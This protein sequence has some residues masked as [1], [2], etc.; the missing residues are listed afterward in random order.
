VKAI[1]RD[2]TVRLMLARTTELVEEARRLHHTSPTATAA[3]GRALTAAAMM[4]TDLKSDE[5]LTI[6]IAGGG[7]LGA[8][9]VAARSDG[10]VRGYVHEPCVDLP[11]QEP[12]KLDVGAAVGRDGFL[13]VVRDMGLRT[14]FSGSVPL[15]SGE[16]AEDFAYYFTVSEQI[17]S[18]VSLGVRVERDHRVSI[19]GGLIIQ[20]LPGA[21]DEA[22]SGL[23]G[24]VLALGPITTWLGGREAL[25]DL[26]PEVFGPIE[27]TV[28][29]RRPLAFRCQCSREK[30]ESILAALSDEDVQQA[31]QQQG[32]LEVVCHFCNTVYRFTA[33]EVAGIRRPQ[34][35]H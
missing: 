32:H 2:G 27:F 26:L 14:P 5:F 34:P 23:E 35:S 30:V 16:I 8:I 11:E 15:V 22:L 31:L 20:A 4:A 25:E 29:D 33:E 6:R 9:L 12:G 21:Q 1:S 24:R 28:I 13:E 3:L 18:L 19:A 7:P 10:T 17:P